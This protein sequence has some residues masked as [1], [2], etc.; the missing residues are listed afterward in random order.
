MEQN[1]HQRLAGPWGLWAAACGVKVGAE[2]SGLCQLGLR[3]SCNGLVSV[4][5]G[6]ETNPF[7]WRRLYRRPRKVSLDICLDRLPRWQ[8]GQ[9]WVGGW[10]GY[11][12]CGL[13]AH[14]SGRPRALAVPRGG[15][16][17]Q[18][19]TVYMTQTYNTSLWV[20]LGG[21]VE[22]PM[23]DSSAGGTLPSVSFSQWGKGIMHVLQSPWTC[24]SPSSFLTGND[25]MTLV[26]PSDSWGEQIFSYLE[27]R[28]WMAALI[29]QERGTPGKG[30][31]W[32]EARWA[33]CFR[34][35]QKW[36]GSWGSR[37]A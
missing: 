4:Q 29:S 2:E 9:G 3:G 35:T 5:R 8:L 36:F 1:L 12:I 14:L 17:W 16:L 6:V 23:T 26:G 34:L 19:A 30:H 22:K 28:E 11:I 13:P 37:V 33:P 24:V 18:T 27:M 10:G 25:E 21:P 32:R 7:P 15:I 20:C 31:L